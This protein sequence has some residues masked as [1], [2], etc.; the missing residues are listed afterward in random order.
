MIDANVY[1]ISD[2]QTNER[3]KKPGIKTILKFDVNT[4]S[5]TY[6]ASRAHTHL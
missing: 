6:S 3:G 1:E 2:L 5:N 4:S